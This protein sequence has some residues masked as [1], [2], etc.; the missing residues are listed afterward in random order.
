M[1][2][3]SDLVTASK[4]RSVGV[5]KLGLPN[6]G[7]TEYSEFT[8]QQ[9]V[10]YNSLLKLFSMSRINCGYKIMCILYFKSNNC[11]YLH[12]G[13]IL[14]SWGYILTHWWSTRLRLR[15]ACQLLQCAPC[16]PPSLGATE[17]AGLFLL[18]PILRVQSF[19]MTYTCVIH[20]TPGYTRVAVP[21]SSAPC[22]ISVAHQHSNL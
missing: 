11:R 7:G 13:N 18:A 10:L 8:W 17:A 1:F 9:L 12:F 5:I 3:S 19:I 6:H 22:N 14:L 2:L 15:I 20:Y 4:D 16:L 21:G